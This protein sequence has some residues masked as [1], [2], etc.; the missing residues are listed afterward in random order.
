[1]LLSISKVLLHAHS[2][3]NLECC[4]NLNVDINSVQ[5][6]EMKPNG[7]Y[8]LIRNESF[9]LFEFNDRPAYRRD[10]TNLFLR[11]SR[12]IGKNNGHGQ[13]EVYD[14]DL[15]MSKIYFKDELGQILCPESIGSHW[16][17]LDDHGKM[18]TH[19][20]MTIDCG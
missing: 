19:T 6:S 17:T 11:Y 18:T 9:D 20:H 3:K 14:L 16:T 10:N 1:M 4:D 12:S 5:P 15:G 13:W 2:S 8:R 7:M